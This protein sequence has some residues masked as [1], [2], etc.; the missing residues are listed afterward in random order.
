MPTSSFAVALLLGAWLLRPTVATPA[1]HIVGV[2][3]NVVRDNRNEPEPYKTTRM[4][5]SAHHGPVTWTIRLLNDSSVHPCHHERVHAVVETQN[6]SIDYVFTRPGYYNVSAELSADPAANAAGLVHTLQRNRYV[7]RE[8]RALDQDEWDL[9]VDAM[10]TLKTTSTERGRARYSCPDGN[11][12]SYREADFFTAFHGAASSNATCDQVHFSL[13]QEVSHHAWHT[14]LERALQCVHPSVSLVWWDPDYDLEVYGNATQ[15]GTSLLNS[16]IWSALYMGGAGNHEPRGNGTDAYY[17]TDGAFAYYPLRQNRTGLCHSMPYEALRARCEAWTQRDL[18]WRGPSN[19][20]GFWSAEPRP[21]ESYKFVSRRPGYVLNDSALS[22]DLFSAHQLVTQ[23]REYGWNLVRDIGENLHG[24]AHVWVSGVWAPSSGLP[25]TVLANARESVRDLFDFTWHAEMR[26]RSDGCYECNASTCY[27]AADSDERCWSNDLGPPS[28]AFDGGNAGPASG[29]WYRWLNNTRGQAARLLARFGCARADT[30]TF[31][32]HAFANQDPAFYLHHTWLFR[33]FDAEV[34]AYAPSPYD[35][36]QAPQECPGQNAHEESMHFDLVPYKLERR[37]GSRHT[38][39]DL[40]EAWNSTNRLYRWEGLNCT[41]PAIAFRGECVESGVYEAALAAASTTAP[42][43]STA[44][45][46]APTAA[47]AAPTAAPAAPPPAPTPAP[48]PAPSTAFMEGV[49]TGLGVLAL[50][51]LLAAR[52][53]RGW[54]RPP[55]S[56]RTGLRAFSAPNLRPPR[57]A[58]PADPERDP[59][60]P[61]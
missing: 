4:Q 45:P 23:H 39:V 26:L 52:R 12:L 33:R 14:L 40:L 44:T 24:F 1:I 16:P 28:D 51:A 59:A 61:R 20:T 55:A 48:S 11:P 57:T 30:G 46:A 2:G 10:W 22:Y 3:L 41:L 13:A 31:Q 43:A 53:R 38:W 56:F 54:R 18:G 60:A 6:A 34:E 32:R 42:A 50:L 7:R 5:V 29:G 8:A 25:T 36:T 47:P 35:M 27:C 21:L 37:P 17:V 49:Y 9:W 15:G 58:R 19:S